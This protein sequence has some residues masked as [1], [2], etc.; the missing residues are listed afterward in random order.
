MMKQQQT[1]RGVE[2]PFYLNLLLTEF[3]S[4]CHAARYMASAEAMQCGAGSSHG[5]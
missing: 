2:L 1:S 4:I 3:T 5:C